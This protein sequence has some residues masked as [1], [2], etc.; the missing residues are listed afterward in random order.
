MPA[1]VHDH[2]ILS[3]YINEDYSQDLEILDEV[4]DPRSYGVA[5]ASGSPLR[6]RINAILLDKLVGGK[7]IETLEARYFGP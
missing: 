5:V 7:Y 4:F 2:G 6:E 3:Y 1:M